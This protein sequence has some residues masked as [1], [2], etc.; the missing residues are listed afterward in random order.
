MKMKKKMMKKK[1]K[2]LFIVNEPKNFK[3][4]IYNNYNKF[5][6]YETE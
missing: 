6:H 4:F 3:L 2:H 5:Y 1:N